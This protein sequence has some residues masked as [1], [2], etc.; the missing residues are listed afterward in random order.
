MLSH[1]QRLHRSTFNGSTVSSKIQN[2]FLN[3]TFTQ[4]EPMNAMHTFAIALLYDKPLNMW[5]E[6]N[7]FKT[8]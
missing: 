2:A 5:T 8:R 1:P 7:Y 6:K 3:K 4:T